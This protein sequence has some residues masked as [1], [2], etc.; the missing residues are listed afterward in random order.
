MLIRKTTK[1]NHKKKPVVGRHCN[2]GWFSKIIK[3][4]FETLPQ[5]QKNL[6]KYL[7]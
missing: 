4:N 7:I 3:T 6:L 5:N 2:E 1:I